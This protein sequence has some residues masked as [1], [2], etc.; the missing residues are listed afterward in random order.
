MWLEGHSRKHEMEV[1]G[2]L[3]GWVRSALRPWSLTGLSAAPP[4]TQPCN[5]PHASLC[6]HGN[7]S[8]PVCH[9]LLVAYGV[10]T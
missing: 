9:S 6:F 4:H 3:A 8:R 7:F 5:A 1:C 2:I 10:L